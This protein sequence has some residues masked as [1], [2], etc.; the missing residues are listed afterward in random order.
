MARN[1]KTKTIYWSS[2]KAYEECPQKYL[3][4]RGWPTIDLGNGLGRGLEVTPETKSEHHIIMG[5]TIQEVVEIMYNER[6]W[7]VPSTIVDKCEAQT[8][9]SFSKFLRRVKYIDWKTA[10][11]RTELLETCRQGV[12]GY[13]RTFAKHKFVGSYVG[14]EEDMGGWVDPLTEVRGRADVVFKRKD[15]GITILDGKNSREYWDRKHKA[16]MVYTDPDQLR[17][18]ALCYYLQ[19]SVIPDRLGFVYYRY[20]AGYEY[21]REKE[22]YR[23]RGVGWARQALAYY[24]GLS[25]ASGV[26]WIECSIDEVEALAIRAQKALVSMRNEE[27]EPIPSPT[28]CRLC[29]F[30]DQCAAR[31]EQKAQNRRKPKP[32]ILDGKEGFIDL[33]MD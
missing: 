19:H 16:P 11:P 21:E 2:M 24:E 4:S 32:T 20:P 6:W 1:D 5:H 18:Y 28:N 25:P 27:F 29:D 3:Y 10:P 17:W 13:L 31:Q 7:E 9:K 8:K 23:S 33:G 15:T 26:N 30:N 14:V 12:L 22:D